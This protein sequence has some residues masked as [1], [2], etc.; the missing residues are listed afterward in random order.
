MCHSTCV[1]ACVTAR[2]WR[3]EAFRGQ[4]ATSQ[5]LKQGLSCCHQLILG[6]LIFN[7]LD[8][9]PSS[10]PHHTVEVIGLQM[11]TT[12]TVFNLASGD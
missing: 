12:H 6:Q 7:L 3:W 9:S 8:D 11:Y 1:E 4:L 10:V 2:V 5:V